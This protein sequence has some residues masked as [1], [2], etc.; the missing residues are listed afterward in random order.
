[1]ARTSF[2]GAAVGAAGVAVGGWF[3]WNQRRSRPAAW[4]PARLRAGARLS[5][6]QAGGKSAGGLAPWTPFFYGPLVPTRSFWRLCR[7]VP[8][9]GLFRNPST[10]PDLETFFP[11]NAFQHIFL[12]NASQIGL[13]IPEGIAPRTDQRERSP[14]RASDSKRTIKPG[15]QGR[16]P[17]PLSPHFSGEMGTPPGQAG[18]PGRCAPR[19]VSA[20]P[21]R[22][23]RSTGLPLAGGLGW[24]RRRSRPATWFP[25]R[26]RAGARLSPE[27]A[28]GKSA[29]GLA[30]WTPFFY[31][32]LVGTRSFWRWCR[33]VPVDGL[34]RHPCT[35]PD[36]ETFFRKN[37]F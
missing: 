17:G 5:P 1:M 11:K 8:V 28:G 24:D 10:C 3:R 31:G 18:P 32:P 30:P 25:A 6:G 22:R 7:I 19:P 21:T 34:L 27:K 20:L 35:C 33:I 16:S 36:L 23:V 29:G 12:E 37:A 4:V 26:L 2:L 14:K 13:S 9:V 15:V